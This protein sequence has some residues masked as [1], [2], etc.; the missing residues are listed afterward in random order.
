[1][2]EDLENLSLDGI[3]KSYKKKMLKYQHE[4]FQKYA[5][6]DEEAIR[7]KD[8]S[9]DINRLPFEHDAD[10]IIHSHAY[11]RQADKT[12]VYFWIES[13][14]FQRRLL[15]VNLVAKIARYISNV[16][17]LNANLSEAIALGHDIGHC[18]FGHDGER[19]F[20]EVCMEYGIGHFRH[21][22][23]S[24]WFLQE[25]EMQNL[26]LQTLD[27]IL[28]HN[29]EIQQNNL[30]PEN[31][32]LSWRQLALDMKL[33]RFS[34]DP[35]EL[36]RLKAK[37]MEGL[38]VRFADT[39]AYI[40]RDVRDAEMLHILS[41]SD[42]P[43]NVRK[44]LGNSNRE[45]IGTL[46]SDLIKNSYK[47]PY[48]GYS[49]KIEEA[50]TE[51]FEFNKKNIYNHA[52]NEKSITFLKKSFSCLF[53]R[54]LKDLEEEN[55]KSEIYKDHF[56][57]NLNDIRVRYPE[58]K[59]LEDYPYYQ[60]SINNPKISVRDFLAGATDSYFLTLLRKY[61]PKIEF[62]PEMRYIL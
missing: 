36:R 29:G 47:R 55:Q 59:T 46:I 16:L 51:L 25:I 37:T 11:S 2:S 57:Y 54:F 53:K 5:T 7:R 10:R 8:Y 3:F 27:G 30:K 4:T 35:N 43:E 13:D 34:E 18:P 1:M 26:T 58:I 22:Y 24:V 60:Y 9:E 48:I 14:L 44:T 49:D 23:E 17:G 28:C 42:L 50:L 62:K 41:F 6:F 19:I 33:V 12:Q 15:H 40:S 39:I 52:Q 45:I 20:S 21:N 38:V 31:E 61:C 56:Q 32:R